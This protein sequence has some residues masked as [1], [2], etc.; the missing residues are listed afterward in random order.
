MWDIPNEIQPGVYKLRHY[1]HY[2]NVFQTIKSYIGETKE[3][4]VE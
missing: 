1:G 4:K 2:K 3:F